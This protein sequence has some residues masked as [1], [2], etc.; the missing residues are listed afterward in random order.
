MLRVTVGLHWVSPPIGKLKVNLKDKFF[1]WDTNDYLSFYISDDAGGLI[2]SRGYHV[3]K[4]LREVPE[5]YLCY[6]AMMSPYAWL[7]Q[8]ARDYLSGL[9]RLEE[10]LGIARKAI[11][12]YGAATYEPCSKKGQKHLSALDTYI[13]GLESYLKSLAENQPFLTLEITNR[14]GS[15]LRDVCYVAS[16]YTG[17][18]SRGQIN[19]TYEQLKNAQESRPR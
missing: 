2:M 19:F 7:L 9:R 6:N 11:P 10:K 5:C 17:P 12:V 1:Y 16:G 15:K 18:T 8:P 13:S 3:N 4:P 14:D